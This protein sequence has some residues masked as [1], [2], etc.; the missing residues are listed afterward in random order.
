MRDEELLA[1]KREAYLAGERPVKFGDLKLKRK[2]RKILLTVFLLPATLITALL[3]MVSAGKAIAEAAEPKPILRQGK[4]AFQEVLQAVPSLAS[5]EPPVTRSSASQVN[6]EPDLRYIDK[7][8]ITH[9]CAC[10]KCCGKAEDDP[11]Y[12]ITATGTVVTEG[13]TIAVDPSV[14]PYGSRV[15]VFYDDGRICCYTAEDCGGAIDGAAIDV[16]ISDHTRARE[17]GVK[18][19]SVYIVSEGLREEEDNHEN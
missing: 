4:I 3:L 8:R 10:T 7:F 6:E 16:Y 5:V 12:G 17:L 18:Y 19:G 9:Y 13:R 15:A 1:Y 14:I 11:R 2:R